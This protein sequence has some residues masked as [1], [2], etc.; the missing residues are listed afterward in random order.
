M[1]TCI[2]SSIICPGTSAQGGGRCGHVSSLN[3]TPQPSKPCFRSVA[4]PAPDLGEMFNMRSDIGIR[5]S[6]KNS[7]F[8]D[9]FSGFEMYIGKESRGL[10]SDDD[11]RR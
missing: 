5:R 2:Q 8:G 3:R 7:R 1:L 4:R 9:V 6:A 11:L 10:G